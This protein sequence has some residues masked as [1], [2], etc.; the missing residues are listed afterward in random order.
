MRTPLVSDEGPAHSGRPGRNHGQPTATPVDPL[1]GPLAPLRTPDLWS[2]LR[3]PIGVAKNVPNLG[4]PF[5]RLGSEM[6]T[7]L[8]DEGDPQFPADPG[9]IT[10]NPPP[11]Q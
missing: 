7:P 2:Q 5:P 1:P 8:I 6:R 4:K 10:A 9:E 3:P 11:R